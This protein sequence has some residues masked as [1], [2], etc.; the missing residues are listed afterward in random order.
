MFP[1]KCQWCDGNGGLSPSDECERCKGTGY[2]VYVR[3][4]N[5]A[6]TDI[7]SILTQVNSALYIAKRHG[8]T[9]VMLK[10]W[11]R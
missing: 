2:S 9:S 8:V 3:S 11:D 10:G 7:Q 6:I 5:A 1:E 4:F